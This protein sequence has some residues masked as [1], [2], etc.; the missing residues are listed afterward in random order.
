MLTVTRT[1]PAPVP[2]TVTATA[3]VATTATVTVTTGTGGMTVGPLQVR[4]GTAATTASNLA[5]LHGSAH[6]EILGLVEV[7]TGTATMTGTGGK[8]CP[9]YTVFPVSALLTAALE[10]VAIGP[11]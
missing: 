10:F 5:I 7:V 1:S 9:S 8:L 6:W 3:I 11:A 4:V 2:V